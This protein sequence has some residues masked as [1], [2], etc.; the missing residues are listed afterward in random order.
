[1]AVG[2]GLTAAIVSITGACPPAGAVAAASTVIVIGADMLTEHLTG[3][4]IHEWVSDTICNAAE[5]FVEDISDYWTGYQ[6]YRQARL[7]SFTDYYTDTAGLL[8]DGIQVTDVGPFLNS[9]VDYFA[10]KGKNLFD[11]GADVVNNAFNSFGNFLSK[12]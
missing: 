6:D 8:R 4:K 9:T 2:A 10:D 12:F 1:M 5:T 11:Y 7:N 3:R